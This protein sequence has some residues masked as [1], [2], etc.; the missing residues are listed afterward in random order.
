[1]NDFSTAKLIGA[2]SETGVAEVAA[3]EDAPETEPLGVVVTIGGGP[4]AEIFT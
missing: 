2:P 3:E 4:S 1:M